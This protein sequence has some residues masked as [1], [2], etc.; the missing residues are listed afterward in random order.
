LEVFLMRRILM[1]SLLGLA[2]FVGLG[3]AVE[4]ARADH[5]PGYYTTRYHGPEYSSRKYWYWSHRYGGYRHHYEVYHPSRPHYVYYYNPY[6]G[7]YWG[8]YD[9]EKGGFS[10][11]APEHCKPHLSQIPESAFP[12]PGPMPPTDPD[13]EEMPPP[14]GNDPCSEPGTPSPAR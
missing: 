8:R 14:P 12:P 7:C 13:G 11:L 9:M 5:H 1:A 3:A 4:S 10:M 2:A 6:K